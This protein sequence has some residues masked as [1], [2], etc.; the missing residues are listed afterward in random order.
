MD[1]ND[2]KPSLVKDVIDNFDAATTNVKEVNFKND[3]TNIIQ[4]IGADTE[5]VLITF[6]KNRGEIKLYHNGVELDKAVFAKQ[7]RANVSFY[8]LFDIILDKFEDWRT[9]WMN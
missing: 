9:A 3:P 7:F 2:K 6:D 8:S 1:D 5:A 4:T